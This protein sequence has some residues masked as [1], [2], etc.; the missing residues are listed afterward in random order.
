MNFI[1]AFIHFL[2]RNFS[3]SFRKNI[4]LFPFL[5]I[6]LSG[7]SQFYQLRNYNIK[8]GLPSSEVYAMLQDASGYLWFTTD[9]G[10]SRFNGYEFKN[11]S[12]ENG[13][14][15]NTNFGMTED[16]KK[17][18]W[19]RSFSGKLSYFENEQI[20]T[21]PCNSGIEKLLG[22]AM[23]SSLY[24]DEGDTIWLGLN[25]KLMMKINPP[26]G[27][28]NMKILGL[29]TNGAYLVLFSENKF[30]YGGTS[31]YKCDLTVYN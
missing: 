15:D 5:F 23:I 12:T 17:R 18:I 16:S 24:V 19:F 1:S 26:W 9:M 13:L 7:N 31:P 4:F 3:F 30:I 14:A 21:P 10:V 25:K 8:D 27:I 28:E 20:K 2:Q 11:Y 6:Y 22:T 29:K